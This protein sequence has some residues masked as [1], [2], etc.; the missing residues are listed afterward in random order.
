MSK[1]REFKSKID[2][3]KDELGEITK[4]ARE[5]FFKTTTN[6]R[7]DEGDFGESLLGDNLYNLSLDLNELSANTEEIIITNSE[8][9]IG[10]CGDKVKNCTGMFTPGTDKTKAVNLNE[11]CKTCTVR[12]Q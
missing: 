7:A 12:A 8:E 10:K 11:Q 2:S 5:E 1:I 3:L 9:Q 4:M 6:T